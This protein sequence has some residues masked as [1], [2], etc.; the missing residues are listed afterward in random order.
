MNTNCLLAAI[1]ATSL[2]AS[3]HMVRAA[4]PADLD[5]TFN[6]TGKVTTVVGTGASQASAVAKQADGKILVA[7]SCLS[8]TNSDFAVVRYQT[9][10]T[11]DMTFGSGG[12]VITAVGSGLDECNSVAVQTDGKIV[13]AGRSSNGTDTDVALV[14]YNSNGTLD[15]TFNSSGKVTT[16]IGTKND[17][18]TKVVVQ[19]D[20]K[21]VVGGYAEYTGGWADAYPDAGLSHFA[22][23]RYNTNGTLD[24]SFNGTGIVISPLNLWDDKIQDLLIQPDGKIVAAGYSA[25]GYT[26]YDFTVARYNTNGTLDTTFNGSGSVITDILGQHDFVSAAALQAD[27]KILVAGFALKQNNDSDFAVVRYNTNGIVDTSFGGVGWVTTPIGSGNDYCSGVAVLASGKIIAAGSSSNGTNNDVALARY[28]P[29]GSLDTNFNGTGTVTTSVSNGDDGAGDMVVQ[30]D[31]KIVVVGSANNGTNNFAAVRYLGDAD[32]DRDGLPDWKEL[33]I[34]TDPQNPDTDGDGLAD[35]AEVNTYHS[36]PLVRDTDGDGFDDGFEVATG[37][38]P[39]DPASTPDTISSIR[40]AVEY[41]FNAANGI[42]YRIEASTDL[43]TWFTIETGIIGSGSVIT[44]LYSI[45]GQPRR[46]LRSRRN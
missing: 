7:G 34:G 32:S 33:S 28:N 27:S 24:T 14:R 3:I 1:T 25:N 38:S 11:L 41:R 9:N 18:A 35:G 42:S 13:L 20:G 5:P 21:L 40:T 12:K 36:N 31:G 44:R 23:A 2:A 26:Y 37:F 6:G 46:Y 4:S 22:L 45:E 10:G 43:T 15:T 29:N 17:A 39:T 8:G 16:P 30:S 19:S